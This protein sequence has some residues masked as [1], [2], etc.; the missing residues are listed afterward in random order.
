[1]FEKILIAN[2]GEIAVRDYSYGLGIG[3]ATVASIPEADKEHS[4]PC[5]Q[6]RSGLYWTSTFDRPHLN[7]QA[8][9]SAAVVT[10]A[11]AIHPGFGFLV[12]TPNLP[13]SVKGRH[14][15]YRAIRNG[16]GYHGDKINARAEMI[17]AQVPV[18]PGS[19][20]E[21]LTIQEAP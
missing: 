8:I 7:M 14:Q 17:K 12:K 4:I 6:M 20:G 15:V 2:R 16:Y 10:G 3:I 18:I 5:W 19:D 13:P 1:M 9:I 11:Q 21:V